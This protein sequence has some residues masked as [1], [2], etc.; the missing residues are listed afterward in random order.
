MTNET[1]ELR[2][3][4]ITVS[5]YTDNKTL[6]DNIFDKFLGLSPDDIANLYIRL[7][8]K[9]VMI[10]IAIDQED[11]VVSVTICQKT[12]DAVKSYIVLLFNYIGFAEGL[13]NEKQLQIVD[14]FMAMGYDA[15]KSDRMAG[16]MMLVNT[17]GRFLSYHTLLTLTR[18]C[19]G[20]VS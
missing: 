7:N 10:A 13:S 1:Q 19:N 2:T 3:Q 6:Y 16:V 17:G 9:S 5:D 12:F 4:W 14:T 11:E 20:F 15:A 8:D 18:K